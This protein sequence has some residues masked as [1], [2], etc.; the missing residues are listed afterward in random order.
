M[1]HR[2][3]DAEGLIVAPGFIDPHTH[4]DFTILVDPSAESKIRQGVTTEIAGNCGFSV[5]PVSPGA[6]CRQGAFLQQLWQWR[7]QSTFF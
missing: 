2:V 4:S 1:G 7:I 3:V 5:F 6:F